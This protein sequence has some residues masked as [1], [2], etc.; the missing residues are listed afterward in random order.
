MIRA[1]P[2]T[3]Q[4]GSDDGGDGWVVGLRPGPVAVAFDVPFRHL[5]FDESGV[6]AEASCRVEASGELGQDSAPGSVSVL[7]GKN[8][9]PVRASG[10]SFAGLRRS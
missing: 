4:L 2:N 9:A 10:E 7:R 1:R 6:G 3:V 8:R 5:A